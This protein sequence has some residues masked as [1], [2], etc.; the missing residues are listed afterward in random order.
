MNLF[1]RRR[2]ETGAGNSSRTHL[3]T[4]AVDTMDGERDADPLRPVLGAVEGVQAACPDPISARVW[5]FADGTVEP[6][7][8]CEALASWGVGAYV[9]ENQFTVPA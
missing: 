7:S 4:L 2:D 8:L 6:E 5:V 9:L 3:I 1:F